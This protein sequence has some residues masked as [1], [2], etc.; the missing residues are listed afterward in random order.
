MGTI[1]RIIWVILQGVVGI[2]Y[3]TAKV[4]GAGA[5]ILGIFAVILVLTSALVLCTLYLPIGISAISKK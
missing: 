4:S 1:D 3:M 5:V 2:L